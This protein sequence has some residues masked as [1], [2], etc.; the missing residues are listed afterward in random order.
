MSQKGKIS[1]V[2]ASYQGEGI[3]LGQKQIFVRFY[4]CNLSCSY[5]DTKLDSYFEY[6]PEELLKEI[7]LYSEDSHSVS[8]TG[9][10]PLFQV[11][12]LND[13]LQLTH[14]E[15]FKNYLET[16]GTLPEALAKVI[17]FVDIIAMDLKLPSSTGLP[18][19]WDQ[20]EK[21]LEIASDKEVFIKA[22]ICSQTDEK[23][24]VRGISIIK[25]VC[26]D[27][28]FILQPNAF[29]DRNMLES[30]L[31]YFKDICIAENVCACIIPQLHKIIGLK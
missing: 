19:F 11:D 7:K 17:S 27:S 24:L 8:F 13:I 1:E 22:V 9:G 5:C 10:E 16:N 29:E 4:G 21:F 28:I 3:Y 30:K 20:H 15:H 18:G 6:E 31:H 23:D 12:F 26:K 14:R 2:F 25:K